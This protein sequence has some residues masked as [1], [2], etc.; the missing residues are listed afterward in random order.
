MERFFALCDCNNFFVSCERV[1]NPSLNGKAVVVLSNNDGCVISR[2]NEAKAMGIKMGQPFFQISEL[3]ERQ[4]LQVYSTN[5]VLYGDMSRRVM[6]ILRD[7]APKIEV[8]SIDEAFMDLTGIPV[9]T[10]DNLGH[11]LSRKIKRYTGIPVSIGIAP[12]KTLAKIASKLCKKYPK[13]EG[14]CLMY[15]EQDI[16]K[17]IKKFP[18]EDIWGIGRKSFR[19]LYDYGIRT[20]ED[21]MKM[22]PYWIR[23]KMSI[24][25]LRTWREL[26]GEACIELDTSSIEK[27]QICVSRSFATELYKFDDLH[28]SVA[29]F[30][31]LCSEKLRSQKCV[32]SK[33]MVFVYTNIHKDDL[34][35]Y[36]NSSIKM[37]SSPTCDSLEIIKN[38]VSLLKD[39]YKENY[40]YKKAGVILM[41][42]VPESSIQPT[43]FTPVITNEKKR[44]LMGTMD[45][46]NSLYG[47]KTIV[48]A[49][50]GFDGIIMNRQH[51]SK[52]FT[53]SW[54]DLITV[55]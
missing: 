49:S 27:Q 37:L 26:H 42:I 54:E 2:S 43:L 30:A 22:S 55:K 51:L 39:L 52:K 1:F 7:I 46:L 31:A 14:S 53:T 18:L 33:I 13:L 9:E 45:K 6:N 11:E 10:L 16:N 38:S 15:R 50:Q 41:E 36:L 25:G 5:F 4:K 47:D 3:V 40:G 8:Y 20:T 35:Q 19:Y 24:T 48:T 28:T 17:V 44:T 21:F 23:K 34:P 12:T 29:N 32:C